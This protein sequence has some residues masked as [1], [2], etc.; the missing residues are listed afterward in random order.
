MARV[1]GLR[2]QGE[3]SRSSSRPKSDRKRVPLLHR[4]ATISA[5]DPSGSLSRRRWP[6]RQRVPRPL[7]YAAILHNPYELSRLQAHHEPHQGIAQMRVVLPGVFPKPGDG[8]DEVT[9]QLKRFVVG[10]SRT[11]QPSLDPSAE[12][13]DRIGRVVD[14]VGQRDD[15]CV[16]GLR[17]IG[18]RP[19][20]DGGRIERNCAIGKE[21]VVDGQERLHLRPHVR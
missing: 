2:D 21:V 15:E 5:P 1:R 14:L 16:E 11:G 19:W 3:W 9:P 20:H 12:G 13:F 6:S 7:R 18:R 8:G 17:R 4:A 10:C